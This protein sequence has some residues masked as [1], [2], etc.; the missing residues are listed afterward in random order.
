M[1]V[2]GSPCLL[3]SVQVG[4]FCIQAAPP[5][6][7]EKACGVGW[8]IAE[9]TLSFYIRPGSRETLKLSTTICKPSAALRCPEG[10]YAT[11]LP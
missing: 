2:T 5:Q 4:F 9:W 11:S 10:L 8:G 1:Q 7:A 3:V 6:N